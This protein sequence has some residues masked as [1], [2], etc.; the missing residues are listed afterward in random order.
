MK[1]NKFFILTLLLFIIILGFN[2]VSASDSSDS[3]D[4][5]EDSSSDLSLDTVSNI[6]EDLSGSDLEDNTISDDVDLESSDD[7]KQEE[8]SSIIDSDSLKEDSEPIYVS[9]S[10]NDDNDGS[11]ANPV[12]TVERGIQLATSETGSHKVFVMEGSYDVFD[13][14]IDYTNLTLEGSGIDKTIF[15]GIGFTGGMFSIYNSTFTIKNL[16]IIETV[17]TGD[18]YG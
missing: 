1:L 9:L 14:H 16:S 11:N 4:L 5:L 15:D 3:G 2:S 8:A 17:N 10:G 18:K 6:E 7:S 13:M 12:R